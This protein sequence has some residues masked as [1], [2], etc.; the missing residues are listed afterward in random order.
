M[1][2][3]MAR[4]GRWWSGVILAGFTLLAGLP[5][6]GD[7]T[8]RATALVEAA[9][10]SHGTVTLEGHT[11]RVTSQTR[12]LGRGGQP[13]TL[14]DLRAGQARSGEMTEATADVVEYELQPPSDVLDSLQVVDMMPR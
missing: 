8:L 6:L 4:L 9:D 5:A 1:E 14:R 10:A 13:I 7:G 3:R 2:R 11:Y 12:L